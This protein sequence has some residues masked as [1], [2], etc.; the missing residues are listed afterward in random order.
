VPDNEE[1]D[2]STVSINSSLAGAP[3]PAPEPTGTAF[4]LIGALALVSAK[5]RGRRE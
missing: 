5:K 1:L 3:V 4:L 2:L